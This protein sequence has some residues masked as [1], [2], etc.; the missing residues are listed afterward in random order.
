MVALILDIRSIFKKEKKCRCVPFEQRSETF[1]R[2]FEETSTY[3]NLT[4]GALC[5]YV[6]FKRLESEHLSMHIAFQFSWGFV[7]KDG[8]NGY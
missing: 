2:N 1:P 4:R 6:W 5:D 7:S 3:N 8:K